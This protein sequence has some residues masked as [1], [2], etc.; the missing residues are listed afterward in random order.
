MLTEIRQALRGVWGLLHWDGE[1]LQRFSPT[2]GGFV[3]SFLVMLAL[4]PVRALM[5]W[6]Q[7]RTLPPEQARHLVPLPRF[8]AV[9]GASWLVSWFAYPLVVFAVAYWFQRRGHVYRYMAAY[10][11]FQLTEPLFWG[12]LVLLVDLN[13]APDMVSILW[14]FVHVALLGYSWFILRKGMELP[15]VTTAALVII[16]F[17]LTTLID[18]LADRWSGLLPV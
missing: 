6:D 10:N 9:Q 3:R 11:W 15:A 4:S 12:P 14:L 18:G 7:L 8:A 16:D 17:L 2:L 13:L 1:S 5:L